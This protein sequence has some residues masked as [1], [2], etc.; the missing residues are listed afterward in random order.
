MEVV[1]LS[2]KEQRPAARCV[3]DIVVYDYRLAKKAPLPPFLV[4][5]L[6]KAFDEQEAVKMKTIDKIHE[7]Q[8]S[9]A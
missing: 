1:I 4:E 7:L 5:E 2:E 3:E 9:L 8:Q 6:A